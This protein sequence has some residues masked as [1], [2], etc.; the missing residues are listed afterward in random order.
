MRNGI[1]VAAVSELVHEIRHVSGEHEIRYGVDVQWLGGL[2]MEVNTQTLTFGSKRIGRDFCFRVDHHANAKLSAAPPPADL[3]LCGLGACVANILVQ[4]ASYKRL[5]IKSLHVQANAESTTDQNPLMGLKKGAITVQ[6]NA[7]GSR[8]QYKQMMMNVARFS[9]NYVTVTRKNTITVDYHHESLL[10]RD[11]ALFSQFSNKK[12]TRMNSPQ[13]TG[14]LYSGVNIIW[15][16]GTQFDVGL[17]DRQWENHSWPLKSTLCVDQ[18]HTALGLNEA[19]NPQEYILAGVASD[20]AQHLILIAEDNGSPLESLSAKMSCTLDMR[21]CFN[22]FDKS[23]IQLQKNILSISS[24]NSYSESQMQEFIQLACER[25]NCWQ[26][27]INACEFSLERND[28][29]VE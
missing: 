8:W 6:L 29:M 24:M 10:L 14:D 12:I 15:R 21:G 9:P 5:N 22:I 3:F 27:F 7:N 1:N 18:P 17:L 16:D 19:P 4:G 11:E 2:T 20:I 25:S 23:A 28:M 26:S 13:S